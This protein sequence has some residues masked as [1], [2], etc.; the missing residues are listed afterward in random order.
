MF[1]P[2]LFIKINF[3]ADM[4]DLMIFSKALTEEEIG[5]LR[6]WYESCFSAAGKTPEASE[7]G[8]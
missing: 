2:E 4:D 6:D 5:E 8:L 3:A 7:G 1:A